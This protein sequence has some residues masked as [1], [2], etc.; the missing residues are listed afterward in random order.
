MTAMKKLLALFAL[1]CAAASLQAANPVLIVTS[2]TNPYTS[3]YAEILR[4]EGLNAFDTADLTTVS[5]TT[6]NAYDVVILGQITLTTTQADMFTTWVNNGGNL[7]AMRPDKKLASLLG[8]V[9]ANATLSDR[10]LLVNTSSAPGAGIVAQTIQYHSTADLYTLSGASTVATLYS[11]ATIPT[12]NPAIS[13]RTG[14]GTGAGRAVAFAYD[15]ARSIVLTRQ[16]NP[17]WAGQARIN[18]GGPVR[19]PDMFFGPA[20]FDPQPDWVDLTKVAIPQ[21]DEHQ[22]LLINIILNINLSKKPLPRFWYLPFGKKAALLM[23]GDDHANGATVA[24]FNDYIAASPAGCNVANWE[25]VRSTSY[26]YTNTPMSNTQAAAFQAQGFEVALH[27]DTGCAD[28]TPTSIANDFVSQ[29][30]TFLAK[31]T[32]IGSPQT[33]RTHCL[34]WSDWISQAEAARNNGIRF[35]TTYYYWP[36]SWMA[37]LP[38][39]FTGSGMPMRYARLDGSTVDVYQAVTQMTDESGQTFPANFNALLDNALGA[40]GYYGIFN[41][42]IHTDFNT[43]P[44]KIASD[45]L[46]AAAQSR[47]V[48]VISALQA[49]RWVDGRNASNFTN[50]A[51]SGNN[52]S[53]GIT[54]GAN[55]NGIRAM[56]PTSAAT[57]GLTAITLNGSPV[58]YTVEVIKG[59]AYAFFPATAGNYVATYG[60]AAPPI[61]SSLTATPGATSA[62]ISYLTDKPSNTRIDY[63]LTP[64][65][66]Q[67]VFDANLVT[68][69]TVTLTGLAGNTT[70]F[71]RVTSVD[72]GNLSASS[73]VAPATATFTTLDMTPPVISSVSAVSSVAGSATVSWTTNKL[74]NSR[75]D[76]GTTATTLNLNVS[77]STLLLSR[78][79]TLNGLANGVTY[80][81]RVTSI[82]GLGNAST[83]PPLTNAPLSFVASSSTSIWPPSATPAVA[84]ENDPSAVELGLKFRTD[85]AGLITGVRF[86]KGIGNTGTHVG[87]LWTSSGALLGSVT[88]TNETASGWQQAN[89]ST[90]IA[91]AANTTY[92]VSYFAPVGRYSKSENFFATSG[93]TSGPLRA[94]AAGIDGPNGVYVY[95]ASGGFPNQSFSSTNYWVDVVFND[96]VPPAIS[97][98]TA[99]TTPTSATISW[100]TNEPATS[101][102]EYGTSASNL[103]LSVTDSNLLLSRSLTLPG[104]T[105]GATYFYRVISTDGANNTSTSP[106]PPSAPLSFVALDTTPPVISSITAAPGATSA[107]IS[108]TT[109]KLANSVVTFGTNPAN[110]TNTASDAAFVLN[111]TL[112]LTGLLSGTVYYY[113]VSST[114]QANNTTT[115]PAAPSAPLSFTTI[116]PNPPVISGVTVST[117]PGGIT[118][119]SWTTNK[120]TTA[121]VDYGVAAGSLNLNASNA[122]PTTSPFVDLTGLTAGVTYFYRVT[123]VDAFTN[124]ATSPAPPAAPSSFVA[125]VINSIWPSATVPAQL[126]SGD[127]SA[128]EL[129]LKFRSSI[130]GTIT[131][132]RFYKSTANTGTHVGKLW[133]STGTLLGSVIFTNETASGWQQAN[134]ATPIVINPNTT[135]VVSYFAPVGRYSKND[136]FFATSGV[137]TGPL[138]ALANGVDGA[139]GV[140][141]YGPAGGFPNQTYNSTNYWVDVVFSDSVPLVISN[142]NAT[143]TATAAAISWETS[144]AASSRV[145]Y[146]TNSANLNLNVSNAAL[147]TNRTLNLSGLVA[148]TTYFYRVTSTDS[149][150]NSVTS[151]PLASAPASFVAVSNLSIWPPSALPAVIQDVETASVELGLKFRSDT[152]GLVTGVRFY[153]GPNNT[154]THVGKLW[155]ATGTLLGSV[156]FT[157]ETASGWQQANF[158]SPIAIAANTTYVVSYLAPVGR[159]SIT[160]GAFTSAAVVNGPL[161]ALQNGT[162]GANGVYLY[163]ATG[164]FPTQSF[165]ASNYWVDVVFADT[166]A[167]V[168]SGITAVAGSNTATISLTTN[169]AASCRVDYGTSATTLNLSA[170]GPTLAAAHSILLSGLA[171]GVT[172]HYRVTCSDAAGLSAISPAPPAV[173]L[174]F[175]PQPVQNPV[176][177]AV[178]SL[179]GST[180]AIISWSTDL[181]ANGRVDYGTSASN[182]NLSAT[183]ATFVTSR[184]IALSGLNP[185]TTYFFRVTSTTAQGGTATS[186]AT[187]NPAASFVTTT[188]GVG[189]E[190]GN[191]PSEWEITG[192]GD[193]TIQGF[194]TDISVNKGETVSFKIN[195]TA[196]AYTIDIYRLGFYQGMG[197]KRIATITPSA[198]LPQVQPSCITTASTGLIDCGN[199]AVSASWAVPA[200]ARSGVYFA[201]PRRNDTGGASHIFFIVRDDASTA[202]ILFQTSDTTWQAYNQYGG[203]SLYVG[204]PVGRAYKVSYNRPFTTRATS[205]EDWV[206]NAEYPM[207]RW[208]EANGYDVTYTSGVDSDRRGNLIRNHR[209]FLSV[210]H[211]EYWSNA[212]RLNVE[213]ARDTGVHL[214][215]FSGNEVFWKT[216]WED[217]YRTLVCYKE[218]HANAKIDPSPEWTGTWRDARFSPPSNGGRPENQLTGTIF[219]VN[220]CDN[221]TAVQVPAA[222]GRLRFWR[223]TNLQTQAPGAVATLTNNTLQYEWN[224]DLDNGARPPGLIQLSTA[225]YPVSSKLTDNGSSFAPGTATHHTVLYR[226]PSGA[227]VFGAGTVQWTWG[228]D[229]NHDRGNPPAD[230]R[231]QQGVV[232]LFADMG[233]Q[234]TSLQS[235]LVPATASTDTTRPTT[236]ITSPAAGASFTVGSAITVTGTAAD[237]GGQVG[238]VEYSTDGIRWRPASGREN[239]TFTVSAAAAGTLT[240]QVRA[241]DDSLNIQSPVTT[242][243]FTIT[244]VSSGSSVTVFPASAVPAVASNTDTSAVE[245]GMKFRSSAAGQITGIRF[246]KGAGNTGTHIGKLWTATGTLLGS[247]T[248]TNETATGW[249]QANFATPINISANTTYVVSYNAPVGRYAINSNYFTTS[250]VN[251]PLTAL[252]N[253]TDGPNGVYRYG[254]GT[255][256]PDQ[257]WQASNYWVDVVFRIP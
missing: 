255:L 28:Y 233:I 55:T 71:Y 51:W 141:L 124:S 44:S 105:T 128:V 73:P 182:L 166:V 80:F 107:N 210:G 131:G 132:V 189:A 204:A 62:T 12:S 35:D 76:Y 136:G 87:R 37:N 234:P 70:Y 150:G 110:L 122:T 213:T 239:W 251:A 50:V 114:D 195:S 159:Y 215:F 63:G 165:N 29:I 119:I 247:V 176:I 162:D 66:G 217:T 65:L 81:Y 27:L 49:L 99:T 74:A 91:V 227:L 8:L 72:S 209:L 82:D 157:N 123:S 149:Q 257:T 53:F 138:T 19:S 153:K 75:V 241:I 101:R 30:A 39:F 223:N 226:A 225:T 18:Q 64:A 214:A 231:M 180:S 173:P 94:L 216:R 52:L 47:G 185:S 140:Y 236:A 250:V 194:A 106:A 59:V 31:Y 178:N 252:Q 56:I 111:R 158:A 42:N 4:T 45:Q 142:V 206:F 84:E 36:P 203:N 61:I 191:P 6:L 254:T 196:A 34:A 98:I 127:T 148:G 11:T 229:S 68:S 230:L 23:S 221:N 179:P 156:T 235:G 208:L 192:A 249:Q 112:T 135:Y 9:D 169:E 168:L 181:P 89:F 151:P 219:T 33:N 242:R 129:G 167:P 5:A 43:G 41:A 60:A 90:P 238:A 237:V 38:G 117:L 211:D 201:R 147:V 102:I 146:G 121:R 224:E 20:N 85:A 220:C 130:A 175:T 243:N 48:P 125:A 200:T 126:D 46:I 58:A 139:N 14:I 2:T 193:P 205:P 218:T 79:L 92:V 13:L 144:R 183:D 24:R 88:F 40:P 137:T 154:G 69:R 54:V 1:L 15:L 202:P 174:T 77:D 197:A 96:N 245:L 78:N 160:A 244:T 108:W 171:T 187:A 113:R 16:G 155:S 198:S 256:F 246:F 152:G 17:A 133:S 104:L 163:T 83:F 170:N 184:S 95:A 177:T 199:W 25:C 134:F 93:V 57:G 22:R 67:T 100:N 120:P 21:A 222:D 253:G 161:R 228:L 3:Y 212:Q 26:I 207:I 115:S 109:N 143:A 103:N 118:R 172:Y 186:P 145:D 7:I 232:N 188:G 86:F 116:D 164:A 240:V 190:P 97:G 10:Y 32:S 248:F